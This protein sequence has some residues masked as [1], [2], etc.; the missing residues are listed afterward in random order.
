MSELAGATSSRD[1]LHRRNFGL[2]VGQ[3]VRTSVQK[4]ITCCAEPFLRR[5]LCYAPHSGHHTFGAVSTTYGMLSPR[6]SGS[7]G[8][9]S[10]LPPRY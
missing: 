10:F 6:L 4:L 1:L 2:T 3:A 8:T 9:G 5:A 7:Q